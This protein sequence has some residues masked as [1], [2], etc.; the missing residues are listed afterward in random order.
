MKKIFS[1]LVILLL[2][3]P[4]FVLADGASPSF[5]PYNAYVSDKDGA[6]LYDY[7]YDKETYIRT[8]HFLEYNH[9]IKVEDEEEVSKDLIYDETI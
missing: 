5:A 2:F 6:S 8:K 9:Q 7:D 3:L 4:I 1:Y